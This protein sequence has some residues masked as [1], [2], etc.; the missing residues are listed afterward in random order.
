MI[1]NP[2]NQHFKLLDSKTLFTKY[3]IENNLSKYLPC[4]Y[5]IN[6]NNVSFKYE[7]PQFPL[8]I[9]PEIG[10]CGSNIFIC[11]NNHDLH[12][13]LLKYK[14]NYVLQKY[15]ENE[16]EY[17]GHFIV[18]N[19]SILASLFFENYNTNRFV[20]TKN[21]TNIQICNLEFE[22]FKE[23]FMTLKY[24]GCACINFKYT[25]ETN[26]LYIFE[27]NPRLGGSIFT[28]NQIINLLSQLK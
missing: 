6:Q 15:V 14:G 2:S 21:M 16:I 9:K 10:I 4:T 13:I 26:Q 17:V 28:K 19:G 18:F 22:Q 7:T 3:F 1:I 5:L 25:K 8:I 20:K 12:K 11:E 23:I 24:T 27:I